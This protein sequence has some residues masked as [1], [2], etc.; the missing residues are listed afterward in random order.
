MSIRKALLAVAA[1]FGVTLALASF[2]WACTDF[3][4]ITSITPSADPAA[5]TA[6]VKGSGAPAGS[7]VELRWNALNGPVIGRATADA[8][9]AFATDAAIPDVPAGIYTVVA[10]DGHS[11]IAGVPYEVGNLFAAQTGSAT[12]PGGSG[13][14]AFRAKS[15]P[16]LG[17]PSSSPWSPAL[18]TVLGAALLSF[19]AA[20]TAVTVKRRKVLATR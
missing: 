4:E 10:S 9:G 7:V 18:V 19:G 8:T 5:A 11:P 15:S 17:A 13:E 6:A 20:V 12:G 2:A 14:L 16:G 3:T 1:V